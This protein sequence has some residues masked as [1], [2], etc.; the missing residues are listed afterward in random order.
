MGLLNDISWE[1]T[2]Q[3]EQWN[4]TL[5]ETYEGREAIIPAGKFRGRKGRIEAIHVGGGGAVVAMIR[6]FRLSRGPKEDLLFAHSDARTF[7]AIREA[8]LVPK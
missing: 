6:P 3:I 4:N 7:W 1:A 5:Q 2:C 8:M